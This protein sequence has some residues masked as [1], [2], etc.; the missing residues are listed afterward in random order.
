MI[1]HSANIETNITV[2]EVCENV[3]VFADLLK[4][5]IILLLENFLVFKISS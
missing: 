5:E 4:N 1:T 2:V 3:L